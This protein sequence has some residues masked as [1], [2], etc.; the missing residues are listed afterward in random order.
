MSIVVMPSSYALRGSDGG[1]LGAEALDVLRVDVGPAP[2]LAAR[3]VVAAEGRLE[4]VEALVPACAVARGLAVLVERVQ[5]RELRALGH[6]PQ[7][8]AQQVGAPAQL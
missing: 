6:R 2:E 4:R 7:L 5:Q 1:G 3:V 8:D